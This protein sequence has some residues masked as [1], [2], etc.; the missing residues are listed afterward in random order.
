MPI[1]RDQAST[2]VLFPESAVLF[3][4]AV[5]AVL[6]DLDREDP[7][8]AV[9]VAAECCLDLSSSLRCWRLE[10]LI[11]TGDLERAEVEAAAERFAA[12]VRGRGSAAAVA[13]MTGEG[14]AIAG[15]R[16]RQVCGKTAQGE[17]ATYWGHDYCTGMDFSIRRGARFVTTNPAKINLFRKENPATWDRLLAEARREDPAARG[18]RL[19]S[20]M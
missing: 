15:S 13:A 12:V 4:E 16:M 19:V 14:Q 2:R 11:A 8:R 6:A 1:C 9:E 10:P 18:R 20:A 7:D 3:R 5:A 17:L